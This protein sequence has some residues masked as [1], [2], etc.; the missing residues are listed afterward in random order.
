MIP[1]VDLQAQYELIRD[2]ITTAVLDVLASGRFVLGPEVEAFEQL[3]GRY[4]GVS[5]AVAVNSG[6]SALHLAMLAVGIGPGDEVIT[7]PLT[8][9]ATAA[10]IEY[11]GAR[12]VF[13]DVDPVTLNIDPTQIASRIT[14]STRAIIPVHLHGLPADLDPILEIATAHRL[15]VIEDAAQAHGAEYRQRRVGG[16]GRVGCFSFYPGKNLGA[17]GEGG[18]LTTSDPDLAHRLRLLRDWGAEQRYH[19]DVKG[20]NYRM[21]G[22]QGAVLRVKMAHLE[23]WTEARRALAQ[24]YDEHLGPMG[25]RI[26]AAPVESRHVYHVYAIRS[27]RRDELQAFLAERG[28]TTGIHY[29]IPVHLQRAFSNLGYRPGD[30]PVAEAAASELLS[31]PIYPELTIEQQDTVIAALGDWAR[32]RG[33]S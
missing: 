7:T 30:F 23:A 19:H 33:A 9:V 11:A 14:S 31:L 6:T 29:P 26:P 10:A 3:F 4:T 1:F 25:F 12:P 2:D 28:I 13:A 5:H 21:D 17:Y 24:R 20:F 8:F 22:V 32:L 18:A 16:I 15:S 27:A